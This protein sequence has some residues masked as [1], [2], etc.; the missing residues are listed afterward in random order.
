MRCGTESALQ[1][2]VFHCSVAVGRPDWHETKASPRSGRRRAIPV[3]M[4]AGERGWREAPLCG[5]LALG[6]DCVKV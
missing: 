4:M 2:F 6:G 5:S 3:D 1:W